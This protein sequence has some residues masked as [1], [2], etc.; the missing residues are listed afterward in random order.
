[1][2]QQ[3]GFRQ[4][5]G[6]DGR[7]EALYPYN[8]PDLLPIKPVRRANGDLLRLAVELPGQT[9][10]LRA[11][12]AQVGRTALYLLDTNDPANSPATPG[13]NSELYGGGL[14][15]RLRQELMLGIGGW[16]LLRALGIAPEVCHL[17]AEHGAF[18]VLERAA[19]F[20]A[21]NGQ[22][23]DVALEVTRAGNVL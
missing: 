7:Q 17:N 4:I 20:M 18:A 6:A 12:E 5:I 1:L 15:V 2:Y 11:W 3:G 16:L 9:V 22:S 23:F 21:Q 14:E 13:I 19:E 10:W 8:D